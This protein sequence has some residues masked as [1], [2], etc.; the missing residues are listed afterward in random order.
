MLRS[1]WGILCPVGTFPVSHT[2][3]ARKYRPRRFDEVSTQEHVS[4]TLRRAVR[5]GRVGH[6]YL[7]CGPRGVGKTTLA[8]VLAMSLN[9]ARRSDDGE[10]CGSCESCQRIWGGTTALDVVEIDAAS[11]RGVD[12]A[13][14]LR[15]RA[16]YAP[17]EDG[18]YK[19]YIVDEAHMLT[20]EAWNALLKIL[21][22]PPPRVTF[23]F[24]TTEPQ[25]IE[26]S[27]APILSRC[28]RFDFRRLGVAE[29]VRRLEEIL[30]REGSVAGPEALR[31]IARKADGGMRDALSILDQVLAL[32][33]GDVTAEVVRKVLGVVDEDRYLRVIDLIADWDRAGLF[34]VIEEL[35]DEGYDLVE[36][37]G[38]MIDA[39]R[40]LIRLRVGE[41]AGDLLPERLEDWRERASRFEPADLVRMLGMAVELESGGSLRR[42]AQPRVLLELLLLR[43]SYLDRT[44]EVRELLGALGGVPRPEAEAQV[45]RA[46]SPSG[47]AVRRGSAP[48]PKPSETRAREGLRAA[49]QAKPD[50]AGGR[51]TEEEARQ[52]RLHDL[53]EREPGLVQAVEEL[54][55]ELLD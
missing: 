39:L 18:R 45:P 9:C 12:D 55:L 31:V 1:T 27:A 32:S 54:D 29:I 24:A 19:V 40:T 17:S 11:N 47:P 8:R 20:R 21:E 42:S 7:F 44:V 30:G 4:E 53:L 3:L 10:P 13:R 22:E 5:A 51:V 49:W 43:F 48:P 38:G 50:E 52:G 46:G 36:F 16:M 2:A 28:Q 37:Y 15:E 26:Q 23:I 34:R 25:K 41:D 6:A 14:D 33:E 35:L